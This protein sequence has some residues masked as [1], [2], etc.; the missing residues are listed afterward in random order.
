MRIDNEFE[1][2]APIDL[3]WNY[4]L[5]VERVAPCLPGAELT[6]VVDDRTWKGKTNVKIGPVAMTFAGTVVIEE[7]DDAQHRVTLK[8]Q[9]MEQRGKGAASATVVSRMEESRDGTRVVI[10]ADLTVSGAAAQYGRGMISD[11]SQRL[12]G[13][14]AKCL[15]TNILAEANAAPSEPAPSEPA[16]SGQGTDPG[17]EASSSSAGSSPAPASTSNPTPS[18]TVRPAATAKPVKGFR[19]G[20]WAF[21]RAVVRFFRRLF[22]GGKT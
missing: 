2:K 19:L 1:V 8:A 6:E 5:D 7:R 18:P 15:E 20:L 3:V 13:E 22:G 12:T 17:G 11:I 14:F 16:T 10:E 9:G 4:L 21:W